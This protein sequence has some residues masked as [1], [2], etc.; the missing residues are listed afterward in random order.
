MGKGSPSTVVQQVS[1][2]A[3]TAP[4]P[5]DAA[6]NVE[7]AYAMGRPQR[8]RGQTSTIHASNSFYDQFKTLFGQ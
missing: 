5:G 8:A 3:P 6:K 7:K 4:T 1:A 2:P